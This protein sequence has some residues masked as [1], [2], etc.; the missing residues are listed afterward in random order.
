MFLFTFLL[1]SEKIFSEPKSYELTLSPG[2]YKF[3]LW[4]G[5]AFDVDGNYLK[6]GYSKGR[7]V[8]T[9]KTPVFVTVGGRGSK[10]SEGTSS[11]KGGFNG[12]GDAKGGRSGAGASD[13][14]LLENTLYHRVIVAG[15]SGGGTKSY[16]GGLEGGYTNQEY[17]GTPG[18][19]TGPGTGCY[20]SDDS[21]D[22]TQ[23]A[24][25][26]FGYGGS[27]ISAKGGGGGGG[28]YGGSSVAST[29]SSWGAGGGGSG[30]VLTEQNVGITPS[31]YKLKDP[32]YF[33][34]DA[35]TLNGDKSQ[36]PSYPSTTGD[37]WV[38]ITLLQEIPI[39]ECP[40]LNTPIRLRKQ[41]TKKISYSVLYAALDDGQD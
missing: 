26:G 2:V 17:R 14:R 36:L 39:K 19:Q 20:C 35:Y 5:S 3:E 23:C 41:R 12:G 33:L 11:P 6:G 24:P 8:L 37:G 1:I 22:T 15:G 27:S 18:T 38:N 25:G 40:V 32:I 21:C 4:G 13:I 31:D 28:W 16:G 34:A 7:I 9:D 30:F 29:G 10:Q